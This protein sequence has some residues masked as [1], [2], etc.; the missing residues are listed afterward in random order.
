MLLNLLKTRKMQKMKRNYEGVIVLNT[1]GRETDVD[2]L[3]QEVG[4][5]IESAAVKATYLAGQQVYP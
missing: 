2:H 4:R 3:V 5:E 1:T